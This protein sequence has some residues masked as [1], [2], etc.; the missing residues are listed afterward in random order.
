MAVSRTERRRIAN[1][2]RVARRN[3][4]TRTARTWTRLYRELTGSLKE[5]A[6]TWQKKLLAQARQDIS[7]G[8]I[9]TSPEIPEK[10]TKTLQRKLRES[11][12][13]GYWLNHVYVEEV[14]VAYEGRKYRGRVTLSDVLEEARL[15]ELLRKFIELDAVNEWY[16]IIPMEA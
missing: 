3:L 13:Q 7:S 1:A 9:D 12:A 2:R 8:Y 14:R 16:E 10:F 5:T 4:I 11:M 6:Q 15:M